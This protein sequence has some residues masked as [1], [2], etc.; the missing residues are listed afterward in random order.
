[1][2]STVEYSA[3][4]GTRFVDNTKALLLIEEDAG[5]VG[6]V[7]QITFDFIRD[8]LDSG[9]LAN[10]WFTLRVAQVSFNDHGV[11]TT[12]AT[13]F[14]RCGMVPFDAHW[15]F[16]VIVEAVFIEFMVAGWRRGQSQ[17]C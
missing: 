6:A 4:E 12:A 8:T 14:T 17:R 15:A 7:E 10:P 11:T 9:K 2:Y 16:L 3:H 1:M 5:P 13:A